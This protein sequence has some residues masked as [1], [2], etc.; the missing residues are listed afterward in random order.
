MTSKKKRSNPS[1]NNEKALSPRRGEKSKQTKI[2]ET[3]ETEAKGAKQTKLAFGTTPTPE[4]P[5]NAEKGTRKVQHK[6]SFASAVTGT[7]T[8][9]N[10]S[11]P[12]STTAITPE[13]AAGANRLTPP[14]LPNSPERQD[15]TPKR[16]PTTTTTNRMTTLTRNLRPRKASQN[17]AASQRPPPQQNPTSIHQHNI[18]LSD[19]PARLTPHPAKSPLTHFFFY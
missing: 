7:P 3:K 10:F 16:H 17:N 9:T 5:K 2:T 8:N 18:A 4:N 14:S 12:P 11:P 1:S 6:L 13:G 15:T 19:I